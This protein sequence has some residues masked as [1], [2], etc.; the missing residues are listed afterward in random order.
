MVLMGLLD[1]AA[2][3]AVTFAGGMRNA[4]YASVAAS[5]F[6]VITIL[7]AWRFLHEPMRASQ[8]A[9]VALVF[10]GIAALGLAGSL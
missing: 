7:L 6:G 2:L 10:T 3:T 9:G 5:V 4:E 1:A 8:W